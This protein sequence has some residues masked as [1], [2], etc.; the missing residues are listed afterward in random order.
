MTKVCNFCPQRN[1]AALALTAFFLVSWLAY[2][3][4]ANYGRRID[5]RNRHRPNQAVIP[6]AQVT[7][8][9][10]DTGV[11]H[12]YATNSAGLYSAPFLV[13]GHYQV[14]ASAAN[15]GKVEEKGLTLQVGETLT[16]DLT[17]KVS[18]ATTTVEVSGSNQILDTEKTEVS[19]VM[20]QSMSR[21]CR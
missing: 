6:G 13:P 19:Q 20:D 21:T 14:D 5:Q 10:V 17:M 15:F 16:I 8:T 3:L 1:L 4:G 18:A 2:P 12:Q 9:D 11:S 7:I